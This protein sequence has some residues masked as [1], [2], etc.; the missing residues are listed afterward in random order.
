M[1]NF[2]Y[3]PMRAGYASTVLKFQ[4]AELK[5]VTMFLDARGVPGAEY[6]G[7]SRVATHNDVLLAGL[8]TAEHFTPA[9]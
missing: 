9:A 2:V 7:M 4:G 3:Y 8:L 5:H 1:G 6:T